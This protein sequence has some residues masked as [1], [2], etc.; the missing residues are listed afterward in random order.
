MQE[1]NWKEIDK[2]WTLFLDRDGVINKRIVDGYVRDYSEFVFLPFVKE[3]MAK[4]SK[5]F[6]RIVLITN[7]Q[8]VGKGLMTLDELNSVHNAM[9]KEIEESGGRID[10]IQACTQLANEPNNFRKPNPQMA[11]MAQT[12]FPEIDFRKS[13]MVGD[14]KSDIEFGKNIGAKTVLIA[15]QSDFGADY[16]FTSLYNFSESL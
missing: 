8:G 16:C 11:Y 4:L 5:V 10:S 2:S 6:G 13:V 7:Q 12:K 9:M 1:T 14:S 3:A 15:E